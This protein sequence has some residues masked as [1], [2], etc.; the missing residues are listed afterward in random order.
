MQDSV[1]HLIASF[2]SQDQSYDYIGAKCT[3][4]TNVMTFAGLRRNY[5]GFKEKELEKVKEEKK[6][7]NEF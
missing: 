2:G 3:L 7:E 4:L 1:D 6:E 5:I